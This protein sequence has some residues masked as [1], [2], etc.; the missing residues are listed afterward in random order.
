MR[1]MQRSGLP[2]SRWVILAVVAL[3]AGLRWLAMSSPAHFAP[4]LPA[5]WFRVDALGVTRSAAN[6]VCCAVL[7]VALPALLVVLARDPIRRNRSSP[8]TQGVRA[9]G[10]D[11][12][13]V[14]GPG[15]LSFAGA[16]RCLLCGHFVSTPRSVPVS[17]SE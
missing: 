3:L 13:H 10:S 15:A 17:F 16:L 8:S 12:D 4:W 11:W 5:S 1:Q 6:V 7:L 9:A 2:G 14:S